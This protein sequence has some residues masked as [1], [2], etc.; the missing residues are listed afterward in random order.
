MGEVVRGKFALP[1]KYK[2]NPIFGEVFPPS[3]E[4]IK[5]AEYGKAIEIIRKY[6]DQGIET[7]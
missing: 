4:N 2:S 5:K 1:Q 7:S 3:L 6:E